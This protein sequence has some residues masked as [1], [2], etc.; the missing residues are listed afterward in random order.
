MLASTLTQWFCKTKY[1]CNWCSSVRIWHVCQSLIYDNVFSC[2]VCFLFLVVQC[3]QM[4]INWGCPK[5][6]T[7]E[8][9]SSDNCLK[10][11]KQNTLWWQ[12]IRPFQIITLIC[13]FEIPPLY[14]MSLVSLSWVIVKCLSFSQRGS[15][16][17]RNR[18]KHILSSTELKAKAACL[19]GQ[20]W[21]AY[22]ENVVRL[23]FSVSH[24]FILSSLC[25]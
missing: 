20:S 8:G 14:L 22:S 7:Y 3:L 10:S 19:L 5:G 13:T 9:L 12:K 1:T 18:L 6:V 15:T 21:T 25:Q 11:I 16:R 17:L 2:S 23:L 4:C 24:K